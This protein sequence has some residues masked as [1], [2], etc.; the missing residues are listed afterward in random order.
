MSSEWLILVWL[1]GMIFQKSKELWTQ[2][3]GRFFGQWWNVLSSIM[4]AFFMTSYALRLTAYG[5]TGNWAVLDPIREFSP[6]F[7]YKI[8][9]LSNSL[10][11]MGMLLSFINLS[12]VFQINDFLGPLQLSLYYLVLDVLKFLLFFFWIFVG[13]SLSIRSLY[14]HYIHTQQHMAEQV[15]SINTSDPESDHIFSR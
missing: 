14:S 9:L 6:S 13:F 4:I 2:G 3:P 11:S 5:I 12:D 8:I 7:S 10:F 1:I 15:R